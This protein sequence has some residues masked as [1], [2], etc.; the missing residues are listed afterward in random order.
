MIDDRKLITETLKNAGLL[1]DIQIKEALNIQKRNRKRFTS[2]L[3]KLGYIESEDISTS[4]SSQLGLVPISLDTVEVSQE[5]IDKVTNDVAYKH[6]IVPLEFKN[7]ILTIATDDP[8]NFLALGNLEEFLQTKLKA[9]LTDKKSLL[10]LQVRI[11]GK[12][13]EEKEVF[14]K[15]VERI[16][17]DENLPQAE[18]KITQEITSGEDTAPIIKLVSLI[19]SEAVKKRASD[20]H[21]EPLENE[22]RVRYR[23][24]GVLHEVPGPPKHLQGS[25]LSR[26]KLMAGLDIAEKRFPQDGRIRIRLL[27]KDL[28]LRVSSLPGIYGES[29]VMRILDKTSLLLGLEELG[30]EPDDQ[31]QFERLINMPN[32]TI[33]VTGPTGSGKTTTL[34]AALNSINKPNK[35]LITIEDPV[36]YQ[37]KGIN[38]VQIKPQVGLTFASGLRAML[39]QAPDIIMVGEIR[40]KETASIAIQAAL[41]G[42]LIFSTLHTNDAPGAVTRLIDMGIK[43][44]LVASTVQAVLAQRLVRRIC[45]SCKEPYQPTPEE[46]QALNLDERDIS[47]VTFYKGRGCPECNKTGYKGRIAIFELFIMNDQL[48]EM[49]FEVRS[50]TEMKNKA[51]ELGMKTLKGDGKRKVLRGITTISEVMRVVQEEEV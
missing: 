51:V 35:K 20:I 15:V 42:H 46:L 31:R 38:Q 50:S 43:P 1:S 29:I 41:T 22:F 2:I 14:E 10:S 30:F 7:D 32:G 39:R 33:L 5:A 27:D 6:R 11:Y 19:L 36:E 8:L 9:V 25:I 28:D 23:I 12:R 18:E 48:R 17:L 3:A 40:D 13:K 16:D 34:Y 37:I 24:D 21:L 44:Y 26:V 49:V 45:D 47:K 4:L